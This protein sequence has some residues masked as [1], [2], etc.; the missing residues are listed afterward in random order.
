MKKLLSA[1]AGIIMAFGLTVTAYAAEPVVTYT[2]D[3]AADLELVGEAAVE[4]GVL[5]LATSASN[6]VTYAVLPANVFE[7]KDFTEGITLCA[8]IFPTA[9]VSDWQRI[10][11]LGDASAVGAADATGFIHTTIGWTGRFLASGAEEDGAYGNIVAA[12][13]TWD[14]FAT[15]DNLNKWYSTILTISPADGTKLYIDGVEVWSAPST[16]TSTAVLAQVPSFTLN[17]LGGSFWSADADYQGYMDNVSIYS[18]VLSAEEI[19]AAAGA[20]PTEIP[21]NNAIKVDSTQEDDETSTEASSEAS[22]EESTEASTESSAEASSEGNSS[23]EESSSEESSSKAPAV[24]EEGN[25][26]PWG[27]VVGAVVVIAVAAGAF[28]VLK[29][30]K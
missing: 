16:A 28:V 27:P 20:K 21:V 30:K 13:Y 17:L 29:K 15:A 7:G 1:A 22:T 2:F 24:K 9:Y 6:G 25:K 12:P 26:F 3:D 19:T 8:D 14:Y 18:G 10:F 23:S 11:E 5:K 4:N